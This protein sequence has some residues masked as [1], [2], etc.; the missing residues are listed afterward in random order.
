MKKEVLTQI[1]NV[2]I[3]LLILFMYNSDH[4]NKLKDL[5]EHI[6]VKIVCVLLISCAALY[7]PIKAILFAIM[8][9]VIVGKESFVGNEKFS[10]TLSRP[11]RERFAS[12]NPNS[13]N[14]RLIKTTPKVLGG[15]E[16]IPKN[17]DGSLQNEHVG[18][19]RK[20]AIEDILKAIYAEIDLLEGDSV[21]NLSTKT[22]KLSDEAQKKSSQD[23]IDELEDVL[24]G[25]VKQLIAQITEND[26]GETEI[27]K[28]DFDKIVVKLIGVVDQK[29]YYADLFNTKNEMKLLNAI[30]RKINFSLTEGSMKKYLENIGGLSL[31]TSDKPKVSVQ[32]VIRNKQEIDRLITALAD[33]EFN[34]DDDDRLLFSALLTARNK[35]EADKKKAIADADD[36]DK[37]AAKDALTKAKTES[38]K[39]FQAAFKEFIGIVVGQDTVYGALNDIQFITTYVPGT[40]RSSV[41][42]DII[43][44]IKMLYVFLDPDVVN[45]ETNQ[46]YVF[47][48]AS[49][50]KR[51]VALTNISMAFLDNGLMNTTNTGAKK[52]ENNDNLKE[53][54]R[55]KTESE[56]KAATLNDSDEVANMSET[57]LNAAKK[58]SEDAD[59]ALT[60]HL[61]KAFNS[62]EDD[63]TKALREVSI[64][65]L[66]EFFD[67]SK[68]QFEIKGII[69]DMDENLASATKLREW[70]WDWGKKVD[71]DFKAPVPVGNY[72]KSNNLRPKNLTS[73]FPK[74]AHPDSKNFRK[75]HNTTIEGD[76]APQPLTGAPA[77]D[78]NYM[79]LPPAE[80]GNL[81][82]RLDSEVCKLRGPTKSKTI[83]K[84]GDV[85]GAFDKYDDAGISYYSPPAFLDAVTTYGRDD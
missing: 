76:L 32:N 79:L 63:L 80:R 83:G 11:R 71:P 72:S 37:K 48:D 81:L 29:T 38:Y 23:Q 57:E 65:V 28:D 60:K 22:T 68:M 70:E 17:A 40:D 33:G 6:A 50:F 52:L 8:F 85:F 66:R 34:Y 20:I 69:Q 19:A 30:Y 47:S 56:N 18:V 1:L 64:T 49:Q 74:S 41:K 15:R 21:L 84:N 10:N 46:N 77:E 25:R 53:T 78:T 58:E 27:T 73:S 13:S 14:N 39:Q 67:S 54:R 12:F 51:N 45:N 31:V 5:M 42:D 62:L 2:I 44:R 26:K 55:L 59:T 16:A 3:V 75:G 36:D 82:A 61:E 43:N 7:D 35:E 24:N 9:V 4:T